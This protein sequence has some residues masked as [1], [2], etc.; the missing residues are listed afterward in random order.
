[1]N[2]KQ[3][4]EAFQHRINFAAIGLAVLLFLLPWT[5]VKCNGDKF[6]SQSGLQKIYAGISVDAPGQGNDSRSET[7]KADDDIGYGLIVLLSF[8]ILLGT[9]AL[10]GMILFKQARP[11]LSPGALA[12]V[13][14]VLLIFNWMIGFPIDRAVKRAVN[15]D[16]QPG[17]IDVPVMMTSER[18]GWF[19]L[20]LIALAIPTAIFINSKIP[21]AHLLA[22]DAEKKSGDP[23]NPS[24]PPSRPV[25]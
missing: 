20:E 17:E 15:K 13:V 3:L 1:M 11:P 23:S 5:N 14:L 6:A 22:V 7:D 21:M 2:L 10:S 12:T 24:E 19:Y 4:L 8:L 9:L 25:K 16:K 18:T